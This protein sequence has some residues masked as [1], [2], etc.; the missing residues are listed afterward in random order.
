MITLSFLFFRTYTNWWQNKIPA[1]KITIRAKHDFIRFAYQ[2]WKPDRNTVCKVQGGINSLPPWNYFYK[3]TIVL[4]KFLICWSNDTLTNIHLSF[5]MTQSI[6]TQY[7][8]QILVL[9]P[10][11]WETLLLCNNVS[12]R[13]GASLESA[14]ILHTYILRHLP[15]W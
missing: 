6:M 14:L 12:H 7:L 11:N 8:A 15:I 4:L 5:I 1:I 9:C 2:P 10:A 13:L 3:T